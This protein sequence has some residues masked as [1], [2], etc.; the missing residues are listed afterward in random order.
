VTGAILC[1]DGGSSYSF[2]PLVKGGKKAS[3][4]V[5]GELPSKARL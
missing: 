1:V 5:Y 4:P 2:L 3:L